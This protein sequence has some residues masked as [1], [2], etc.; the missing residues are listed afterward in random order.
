LRPIFSLVSCCSARSFT[1]LLRRDFL[2][3]STDSSCFR[4]LSTRTRSPA[5]LCSVGS[6]LSHSTIVLAFIW[7]RQST[8]C[9]PNVTVCPAAAWC[10]RLI[11]AD[12][13]EFVS[14][15][16]QPAASCASTRISRPS[17]SG[18]ENHE[19][20]TAATKSHVSRWP[21]GSAPSG[22]R[23]ARRRFRSSNTADQYVSPDRLRTG[24]VLSLPSALRVARSARR[25]ISSACVTGRTSSARVP[26]T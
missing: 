20:A 6:M 16:R 8:S 4:S 21:S 24:L 1:P 15:S 9:S 12:M 18:G 23:C 3:R 7:Y 19:M 26:K 17:T 25:E 2:V 11:T 22:Q 14:L 5:A 10:A 13:R